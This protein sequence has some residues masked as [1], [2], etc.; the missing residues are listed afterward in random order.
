MG[1]R[2]DPAK[3]ALV[4]IDRFLPRLL[5]SGQGELKFCG[6]QQGWI[7]GIDHRDIVPPHGETWA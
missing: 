5:L 2:R 1:D 6:R 3:Q 7:N 4:V